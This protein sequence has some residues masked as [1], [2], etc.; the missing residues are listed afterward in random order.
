MDEIAGMRAHGG[1]PDR[2]VRRW[3]ATRRRVDD[4]RGGARAGVSRRR[5]PSSG[6]TKQLP[7]DL[8]CLRAARY[9]CAVRRPE[10]SGRRLSPTMRG[11]S[12]T[13]GAISTTSE[14][15]PASDVV[16]R[17]HEGRLDLGRGRCARSCRGHTRRTSDVRHNGGSVRRGVFGRPLDSRVRDP[18]LSRTNG[19]RPRPAPRG[20]ARA[21]ARPGATRGD[22]AP[23]GPDSTMS[24][25]APGNYGVPG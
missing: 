24:H 1:T 11:D 12:G 13:P 8:H 21:P 15:K 17:S 22:V 9:R 23:V 20:S 5:M 3:C 14:A 2:R 7:G 19:R 18:S 10:S 16:R 6:A 25:A 4:E